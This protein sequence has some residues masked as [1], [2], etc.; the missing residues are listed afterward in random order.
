MKLIPE[1]KLP[2]ELA[3]N[4]DPDLFDFVE[5]CLSGIKYI[6]IHRRFKR[7]KYEP[8]SKIELQE[9]P[10][11]NQRP[12]EKIEEICTA[13]MSIIQMDLESRDESGVY[14]LQIFRNT[15]T[16]KDSVKAKHLDI[17]LDERNIHS[18]DHTMDPFEHEE[19][20]TYNSLQLEYIKMIQDHS[21]KDRS[22]VTS[23]VATLQEG[24]KSLQNMVTELMLKNVEIE[25][26]RAQERLIERESLIEAQLEKTKQE[27]KTLRWNKAMS[28]LEESG[29]AKQVFTV[30]ADKIKGKAMGNAPEI[31]DE[32]MVQQKKPRK[33]SSKK[34]T[35]D[36]LPPPTVPKP[37]QVEQSELNQQEIDEIDEMLKTQPLRCRANVLGGNLNE[38]QKTEIK[39]ILGDAIYSALE[40]LL[41]SGSEDEAKQNLLNLRGTISP[42]DFNKLKMA[43][44]VLTEQQQELVDQ[45]L[46][47]DIGEE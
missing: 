44:D 47:F 6:S 21:F 13:I 33:P 40:D 7:D 32:E 16:S 22:I 43:K 20:P 42:R 46:M 11:I 4:A 36:D 15:G 8:I 18:H 5:S 39:T 12:P 34:P 3:L 38:E 41:I 28:L 10:S 9:K 19:A 35:K 31:P 37:E 14:R 26:L 24:Y 29:G 27:N 25:K 30:I 23:I 1:L 45:I 17:K 2:D